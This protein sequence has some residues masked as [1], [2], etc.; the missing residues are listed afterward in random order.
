MRAPSAGRAPPPLADGGRAVFC[1]NCGRQ[2]I[3]GTRFCEGCGAPLPAESMAARSAP[4]AQPPPATW[5][6]G[7]G[8]GPAGHPPR[9]SRAG[10]VIAVVLVGVA[11]LGTA[12]YFVYD[13]V[14]GGGPPEPEYRL[15]EGGES[16]YS[17]DYGAVVTGVE[18][19]GFTLRVEFEAT[20]LSDLRRPEESCLTI[21]GTDW[22]TYLS[23]PSVIDL[24]T[25]EPTR[26]SGSISFPALVP[27]TYS[28]NYSCA[29]DY[30]LAELGEVSL[31]EA[32]VSRVNDSDYAVVLGVEGDT[33]HFG[34]HGRA[35]LRPPEQSCVVGG[36]VVTTPT[37]VQLD[38]E[39]EEGAST[40]V[41]SL[42]FDTIPTG[43]AFQYGCSPDFMGIPLRVE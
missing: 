7:G 14:A 1:A 25:D 28:F 40:Y 20:G 34:A 9:R 21:V 39:V 19:E 38:V 26:Y 37:D 3:P 6:A 15:T 35:G 30:S 17:T 41:G 22:Q 13:R 2:R 36:D 16:R 33:V 31:P 32:R 12:G 8:P 43:A 5:T 11:V 42:T 18:G 4:P 27:G 23:R 24:D 29:G 10:L